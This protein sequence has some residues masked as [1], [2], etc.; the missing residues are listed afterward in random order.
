MS[1]IA[2]L[3]PS[4]LASAPVPAA[5]R[6][7]FLSIQYLRAVAALMVV[8]FHVKPRISRMGY[9]GPWPEWLGC[10]VDIFFVISGIIMWLTTY[11]RAVTPQ[12]FLFRRFMRI[13]PLYYIVTVVVVVLMAVAPTL[14]VGGR[15]DAMH[16]LAS[17]AFL[18]WPH[19]VT[20]TFE[21]VLPQGWT[22]N[23]EMLFYLLFALSLF[24]RRSLRPWLVI[25]ALCAIVLAGRNSNPASTAGFFASS[26][27][28][29][30]AFGLLIGVAVTAG[31]RLPKAL[32]IVLLLLGL[33]GIPATWPLVVGGVPRVWLCG[34][35]A[36]LLVAGAVFLEL[37]GAVF[38]NRVMHLLG[39][40]SYSIYLTHGLAMSAVGAVWMR[41]GLAAHTATFVLFVPVSIA[42]ATLAGVITYKIAEKPLHDLSRGL[43]RRRAATA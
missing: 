41:T 21:P 17:F 2:S 33:G 30:F 11:D 13:A 18:P 5:R 26:I 12:D 43:V 35:S 32:A 6:M 22:L 9:D 1:S 3:N 29:E 19:P 4:A 36:A 31:M 42:V 25:G 14:V 37:H 28:L 7:E 39:D 16:V 10:G 27:I 34:A 24:A 23:Y 38:R 15:L 8:A 20:G 40:A